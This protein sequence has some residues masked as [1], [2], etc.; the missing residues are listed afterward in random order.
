MS[1]GKLKAVLFD[2]GGT[3][4]K[5]AEPPEIHRRILEANGVKVAY[6]EVVEAHRKNEEN[7]DIREMVEMG[8]AFWI[9]WNMR[10]LERLGVKGNREILARKIDELWWQYSDLEL[11]SDVNETLV[12]L[13]NTDTKLGIVTNGFERDFRLIL[14][15][16]NLT[17]YFDVV[18][19][20][21]TCQKAKPDCE[22]FLY[23]VNELGTRP[24][25][26]LF[27]GDSVKYDFEGAKRAGLKP[28][29]INRNGKALENI[30]FITCLSEVIAYF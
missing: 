11:Y 4:V 5:S 20:V 28:L 14:E 15:N 10:I 8:L 22:M 30:E 12:Q 25:E 24:E 7:F 13:R 23:A 16:F 2:L 19:G 3:L 17:R 29:L 9:K 1:A 26:T 27:V 6:E 18:V 21:D